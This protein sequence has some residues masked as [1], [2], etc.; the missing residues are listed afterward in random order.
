MSQQLLQ[1]QIDIAFLRFIS[2][3]ILIIMTSIWAINKLR[4]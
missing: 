4:K 1:P 3:S 2:L